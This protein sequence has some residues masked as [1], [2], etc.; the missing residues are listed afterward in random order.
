MHAARK[1]ADTHFQFTDE[2]SP[3]LEIPKSQHQNGTNLYTDPV[4]GEE[5]T[6]RP[7]SKGTGVNN[8]RRGDDFGAHYS[9]T[10]SPAQNENIAPNKHATRSDMEQHW[11]FS[12]PS[13]DKKIYKTAGDGMGGR[14][15][16]GPDWMAPAEG[17]K[18]YKTAGDGMGGRRT[19]GGNR[20]WAIGDESD[21]DL[22]DIKPSFRG[23]RAQAEAGAPSDF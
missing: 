13:K 19:A 20:S 18:I 21:E 6:Q 22:A 3:A 9:M 1:D 7:S 5:T 14:K 2:S 4:N 23:R 12:E 15:S 17:K 8:N 11:A 16:G 10:D